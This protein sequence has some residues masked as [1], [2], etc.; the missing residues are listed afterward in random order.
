M[1]GSDAATKKVLPPTSKRNSNSG[2]MTV[3]GGGHDDINFWFADGTHGWYV[4]LTFVVD[5]TPSQRKFL[6]GLF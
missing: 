1:I 6:R 4:T 2:P 5:S 3:G